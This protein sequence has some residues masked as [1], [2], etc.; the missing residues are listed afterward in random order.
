MTLGF[1]FDQ[2]AHI[3]KSSLAESGAYEL[4][5]GDGNGFAFGRHLDGQR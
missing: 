3:E 4:Q 2:P 5:A 1:A